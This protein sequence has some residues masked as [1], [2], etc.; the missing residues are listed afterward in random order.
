[1]INAKRKKLHSWGIG[2]EEGRGEGN[3]DSHMKT[4]M[5]TSIPEARHVKCLLS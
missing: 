2:H 4:S 1:M 5:K 3:R